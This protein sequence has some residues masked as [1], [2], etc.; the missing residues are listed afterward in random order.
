MSNVIKLN[1]FLDLSSFDSF[2]WIEDLAK[3]EADFWPT[4]EQDDFSHD[5]LLNNYQVNNCRF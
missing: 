1:L 5:Y 3:K 4:L 2:M